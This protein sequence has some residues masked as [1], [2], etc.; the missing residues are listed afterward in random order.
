MSLR[1]WTQ[2]R[3]IFPG[4]RTIEREYV[5]CTFSGRWIMKCAVR[6]FVGEINPWE[7]YA[8]ENARELMSGEDTFADNTCTVI[9]EVCL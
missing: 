4:T 1:D 2:I 7:C 8:G 3:L 9:H 6:A 5:M